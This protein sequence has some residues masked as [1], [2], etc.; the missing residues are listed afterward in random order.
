[1][2]LDKFGFFSNERVCCNLHVL[3]VGQMI[4]CVILYKFCLFSIER[5]WFNL[6]ILCLGKISMCV[7]PSGFWG[8]CWWI[9]TL[10]VEISLWM[11]IPNCRTRRKL[12]PFTFL[13][14]IVWIGFSSYVVSWM[15]TLFG[16]YCCIS[17]S[18][19]FLAL[20]IKL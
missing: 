16:M 17:L 12:Y 4:M 18:V 20:H 7:K 13:M 1:M 2:V 9:F 10:P 19:E 3:C 14:C 11:S 5:V 6:H 8:G 15:M